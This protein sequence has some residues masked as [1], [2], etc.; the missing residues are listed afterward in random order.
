MFFDAARIGYTFQLSISH[1]FEQFGSL[2]CVYQG[3]ISAAAGLEPGTPGL[4][5]D[6]RYQW[7]ILAPEYSIMMEKTRFVLFSHLILFIFVKKITI[8]YKQ[9]N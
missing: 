4:L 2:L 9:I 8:D 7:A 1:K 3:N 6:L 5:S